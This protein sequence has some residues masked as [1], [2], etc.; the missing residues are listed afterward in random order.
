MLNL[1]DEFTRECLAMRI[2][3]MLKSAD[4]IDALS[5]LL[6]LR[7]IPTHVRSYNGPQFVAQA[8]RD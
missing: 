3:R 5:D 6:I 2:D 7:G 1:I 8:L 4:V